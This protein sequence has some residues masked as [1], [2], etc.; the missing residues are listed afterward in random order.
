[1]TTLNLQKLSKGMNLNDKMKLLFEDTNHTAVSQDNESL[2]TPQ[3]RDSII[4]DAR[5]NG[6]LREIRRVNELYILSNYIAIDIELSQFSL[7]LSL[8][9]LEK[10]LMGIILK[11]AADEM[12]GEIL[13][14]LAKKD[15][16]SGEKTIDK[17]MDELRMKYKV[18]SILFKGFDFFNALNEENQEKVEPNN[19][20]QQAFMVS[21]RHAKILKK[22]LFDMEYVLKKSPIDFLP[23]RN[24]EI[25]Q[26]SEELLTLFINLDSTLKSLRIYRDFG[27][28][29][30]GEVQITDPEFLTTIKN[31]GKTLELSDQDK[32]QLQIQIDKHL[33][34][35]L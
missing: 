2:L 18:D 31:I 22:K 11:G 24:K 34:K 8:S 30:I 13:Y 27:D 16:I 6:E 19:K 1:M 21:F 15:E 26:Q 32:E 23:K 4:E 29:I 7:L 28:K 35:D 5:R 33:G 17:K 25:I 14:D 12:I 10:I 9:Y 20:I 3:E